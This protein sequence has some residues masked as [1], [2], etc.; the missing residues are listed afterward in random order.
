MRRSP[1]NDPLV[2]YGRG[3]DRCRR[4]LLVGRNPV[5]CPPGLK[6]EVEGYT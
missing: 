3:L 1:L 4:C 5:A 6:Q 2:D